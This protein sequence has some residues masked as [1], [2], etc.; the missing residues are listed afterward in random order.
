MTVILQ[1]VSWLQYPE[2]LVTHCPYGGHAEGLLYP[3]GFLVMETGLCKAGVLYTQ[4]SNAGFFHSDLFT[5]ASVE[6]GGSRVLSSTKGT[7]AT[8]FPPWD[9][10]QLREKRAFSHHF[11]L[12][13]YLDYLSR[14]IFDYPDI[15]LCFTR[16]FP[17]WCGEN[18]KLFPKSVHRH[19]C[20]YWYKI[21]IF[22]NNKTKNIGRNQIKNCLCK[23]K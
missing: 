21:T 20:L 6:C 7:A 3:G 8:G 13:S 22:V 12:G 9:D 15:Q 11:S 18:Q 5:T 16:M 4:A 19:S 10:S 23:K 2:A 17:P 1:S 14:S